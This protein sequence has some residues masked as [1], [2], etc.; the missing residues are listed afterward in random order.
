MSS[1][2]LSLALKMIYEGW[3]RSE[4]DRNRESVWQHQIK[5]YISE[6]YLQC[7]PMML[8]SSLKWGPKAVSISLGQKSPDHGSSDSNEENAHL[9]VRRMHCHLS[10]FSLQGQWNVGH[11][12]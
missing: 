9:Y 7:H 8:P 11:I 2:E 12:S 3:W 6:Y 4:Q 5:R 1:W 10:F